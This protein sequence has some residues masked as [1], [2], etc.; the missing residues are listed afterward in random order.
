MVSMRFWSKGPPPIPGFELMLA[1]LI[2]KFALGR[3]PAISCCASADSTARR[4]AWSSRL[5][6]KS[7]VS[8]SASVRARAEVATTQAAKKEIALITSKCPLLKPLSGDGTIRRRRVHTLAP[9]LPNADA[10]LQY[11][12]ETSAW[13]RWRPR[14]ICEISHFPPSRSEHA[15]QG[16]DEGQWQSRLRGARGAHAA[17]DLH[18]GRAA[19]YRYACRVRYGAVRGLHGFDG[20]Q[21]DQELLHRGDAG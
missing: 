6:A 16:F 18:P 19:P 9:N 7:S 13:L 2:E 17:R 3:A 11:R 21:G 4:A 10:A 5:F 1:L 8:A 15:G 12:G 20:R 14:R